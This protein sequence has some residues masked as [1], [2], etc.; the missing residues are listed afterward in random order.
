MTLSVR[1]SSSREPRPYPDVWLALCPREALCRP[2]GWSKKP[3]CSGVANPHPGDDQEDDA[4]NRVY[5]ETIA[6]RSLYS[7]AGGAHRGY[8]LTPVRGAGW[9]GGGGSRGG[10]GWATAFGSPPGS[11]LVRVGRWGGARGERFWT[12]TKREQQEQHT[13]VFR[14]RGRGRARG[15]RR[16]S[17][18]PRT[19]LTGTRGWLHRRRKRSAIRVPLRTPT[20]R[21]HLGP[22]ILRGGNRGTCGARLRTWRSRA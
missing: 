8:V 6:V 21:F 13:L 18:G 10:R 19:I 20:F 4:R 5:L 17:R 14:G 7:R 11:T 15:R 12:S 1:T 16:S 9:G 2:T 22:R 3:P